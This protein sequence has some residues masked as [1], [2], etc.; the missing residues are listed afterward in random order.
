MNETDEMSYKVASYWQVGSF[1]THKGLDQKRKVPP[2]GSGNLNY[3][4][5]GTN[6]EDAQKLPLNCAGS[7]NSMV[8]T[9]RKSKLSRH[10]TTAK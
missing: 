9:T 6:S 8:Q 1:L 4:S 3:D 2:R 10:M 7:I 5:H